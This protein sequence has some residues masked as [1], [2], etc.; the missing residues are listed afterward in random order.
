MNQAPEP[1]DYLPLWSRIS[2][3]ALVRFL[4]FFASGWA[5]VA[6]FQ[7]FEYVIFVFAIS[8]I[9]ALILNYPVRYLERFVKRSIA[10][11][12]VIALSLIIILVAVVA[13]ALTLTN[14]IQ[15]YC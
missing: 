14:Q 3:N 2:T 15:H 10:L 9:L 11:G 1:K 6:L 12:L 13:I 7:Y 8:A 5:F 4:L